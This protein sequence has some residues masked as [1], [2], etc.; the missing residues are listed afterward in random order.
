M[1]GV[2]ERLTGPGEDPPLRI[3]FSKAGCPSSCR[4]IRVSC[5][6]QTSVR[7]Q[8]ASVA[9]CRHNTMHDC[10]LWQLACLQPDLPAPIAEP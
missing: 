4:E 5:A 10:G 1:G 9:T 7:C 8:T 3:S 6:A 2:N